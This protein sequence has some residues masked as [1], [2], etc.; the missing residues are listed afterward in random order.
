MNSG[1][2]PV[3]VAPGKW[4]VQTATQ[5]KPFRFGG[6]QVPIHLGMMGRGMAVPFQHTRPVMSIRPI[7]RPP[8][9]G[10]NIEMDKLAGFIRK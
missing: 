7:R 2:D 6:S 5:Q 8:G 1:F 4:K 9:F 3:V 10:P